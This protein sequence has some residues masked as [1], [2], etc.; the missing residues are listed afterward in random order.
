MSGCEK[1][2]AGAG[3]GAER[4]G[5]LV[6]GRGAENRAGMGSRRNRFEW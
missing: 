4:S 3:A 5:A 2:L 1:K 6:G